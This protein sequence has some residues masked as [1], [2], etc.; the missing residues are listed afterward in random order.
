MGLACTSHAESEK[1][2]AKLRAVPLARS[3]DDTLLVQWVEAEKDIWRTAHCD[4][5]VWQVQQGAEDEQT[6]GYEICIGEDQPQGPLR[7]F[8]RF[9]TSAMREEMKNN[10]DLQNSTR[11]L[12]SKTTSHWTRGLGSLGVLP[13]STLDFR[14]SPPILLK[15]WRLWQ[16]RFLLGLAFLLASIQP[17]AEMVHGRR[18]L[19]NWWHKVAVV[20]HFGM[21]VIMLEI[22][23]IL[24]LTSS[25]IDQF[26]NAIVSALD[27]NPRRLPI[28]TR[29]C[30]RAC[31]QVF[32]QMT[33]LKRSPTCP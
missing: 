18:C 12:L 14:L 22:T 2:L 23:S 25:S 17:L 15:S 9:V 5:S 3:L 6:C 27:L 7:S 11:K 30:I 4:R 28:S 8:N 29:A 32:C 1:A 10:A 19:S 33:A 13:F 31:S 24:V 26:G 16:P 21:D 20:M